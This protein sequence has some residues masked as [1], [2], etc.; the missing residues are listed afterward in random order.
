MYS[1]LH[2]FHAGNFADVHKHMTLICLIEYL[3]KKS[4][5]FCVLDAFAGEGLYD[6]HCKESELNKE[7]LEGINPILACDDLGELALTYLSTVKAFNPSCDDL[8]N[9]YPGSPAIIQHHLRDIDRAILVENHPS[10]INVL[11]SQ[12]PKNK[13]LSIHQRDGFEAIQALMPFSEKRG[14]TFI[15]P[16]YEVKS[17]Y[18]TVAHTVEKAYLKMSHAVFAIWYPILPDT[19]HKTLLR[20]INQGPYENIYLN[21]WRPYHSKNTGLIGSG[22]IIINKGWQLEKILTQAFSELNKKIYIEGKWD[23]KILKQI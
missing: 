9:T 5:P 2:K 3:K 13:C 12:F 17:E 7:Y 8:I 18:E 21:E 11:K 1:Y 10:S 4:K 14:L 19:P 22:M 23:S 16:S 6:L 15:D 20:A